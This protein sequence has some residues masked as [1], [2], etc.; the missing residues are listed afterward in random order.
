VDTRKR[1]KEKLEVHWGEGP[2]VAQDDLGNPLGAK[3]TGYR[4]CVYDDADRLAG[5]LSIPGGSGWKAIGAKG[6]RYG[7]ERGAA[8]GVHS[9]VLKGG[10]DGAS[11][12]CSAANHTAR[13]QAG[14]PPGIARALAGSASVTVQLRAGNEACFSQTL[15][16]VK[17]RTPTLF[18]AK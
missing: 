4:I 2:P 3:P 7:D 8:S 6:W 14:V 13:G 9:L 17:K 11:L 18:K 5:P 10:A 1:G 16:D 15:T 12:A